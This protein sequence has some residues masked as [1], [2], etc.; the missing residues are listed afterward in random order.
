MKKIK[1][2]KKN[3]DTIRRVIDMVKPYKK[4]IIIISIIALL[5]DILELIRPYLMKVAIDDYLSIGIATKGMITIGM[6]GISYIVIVIISNL[7]DFFVRMSTNTL[8]EKVVY[9]IRNKLF[10]FVQKANITFHDKTSTGK[11]FVRVTNDAEDI[12]TLFKDVLTTFVKDVVMIAGIICI[13][14]YMSAKLSL[15][16]FIVF[17]FVIIT[18]YFITNAL[19]KAYTNSKNIRTK[20]N[21]FL[22]ESIYGVRLIKVFN[23]QK[24]KLRECKKYSTNYFNSRRPTAIYEGLLPATIDIFKNIGI[25]IIVYVSVNTAFSVKLD[26]GLIYMLI[27]YIGNLFEP[28]TRII[29]NIEVVEESVVSTNKIYDILDK[30]EQVED[31]EEGKYITDLKGKIEFKNVWF[32]YEKDKY[33]LKDVSFTIEPH[34][35]VALVGKT[36]SG[37]TTITNL[38][39]RFYDIQKGQILID[40]IDIKNINKKSLRKNVGTILQDPFIFAR[41]VKDNIKLYSNLSDES[42]KKVLKLSSS[43]KFVSKLPN[44]ENEIA[45]ERGESFSIGQKQLLSFARIFA[46]NPSIFIL[47]EATANIDTTTEKQ[48][49]NAIDVIS[50]D[51][52]SI[53][54]AH[55]LST[56]V[57]V[58]KIIV[59][60]G[61]KIV[62]EGSHKELM[63]KDGYYSKLYNSYYTSLG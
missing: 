8:G 40:G 47:D 33:I 59:L 2:K 24:E 44:K 1:T 42:V 43:D 16:S 41:S 13:M 55:R 22:S 37:K 27:T 45:V 21:V 50:E 17:P 54:I 38:I 12:S 15:L 3:M 11:I 46:H 48:I 25:A 28:V 51:K 29:E 34:Q 63:K 36:G 39:N 61:G 30:K 58:D 52:T 53:F 4:S 60:D 49:Q 7:L 19:N 5:I 57:N 14:I 26:V 62:E 35:S 23:R 9:D 32:A 20:I 6:I 56:V 18:T 31:F 10:S